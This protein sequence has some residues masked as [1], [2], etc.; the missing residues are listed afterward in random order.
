MHHSASMSFKNN[1]FSK[2][3]GRGEIWSGFCEFIDA[4]KPCNCHTLSCLCDIIVLR[5]L[6]CYKVCFRWFSSTFSVL[7]EFWGLGMQGFSFTQI[8]GQIPIKIVAVLNV[9]KLLKQFPYITLMWISYAF[10][11]HGVKMSCYKIQPAKTPVRVSSKSQPQ[12]SSTFQDLFKAFLLNSRPLSTQILCIL[13][14]YF[15][16]RDCKIRSTELFHIIIHDYDI[17]YHQRGTVTLKGACNWSTMGQA[18][19]GCLMTLIHYQV[20]WW[21]MKSPLLTHC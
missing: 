20:Q 16:I 7:K 11:T 5:Y 21:H 15:Y 9:S 4:F 18:V 8:S 1:F 2:I 17:S 12:N 14:K 6:A 3:P 13:R 10:D 19:A